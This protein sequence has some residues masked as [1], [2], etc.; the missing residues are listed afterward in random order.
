MVAQGPWTAG[1]PARRLRRGQRRLPLRHQGGAA[2]YVQ[3]RLRYADVE[4][5]REGEG[6]AGVDE[7]EESAEVEWRGRLTGA[8]GLQDL[9]R[10]RRRKPLRIRRA[11]EAT[12]RPSRS[13]G[14]DSA[15]S[16][17]AARTSGMVPGRAGRGSASPSPCF[18]SRG[19][20]YGTATKL[21]TVAGRVPA[22]HAWPPTVRGT[23]VVSSILVR[24]TTASVLA[25]EFASTPTA[26]LEFGLK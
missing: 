20:P 24:S 22:R 18:T 9:A 4:R 14:W 16:R 13:T 25:S 15:R 5:D 11:K 2:A 23:T 10:D 7:V 8:Q 3:A 6:R 21:T 17:G 26:W 19:V 1:R 12:R